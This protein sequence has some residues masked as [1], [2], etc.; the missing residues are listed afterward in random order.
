MGQTHPADEIE[1][2]LGRYWRKLRK[3]LLQTVVNLWP[4]AIAVYAG[5][6]ILAYLCLKLYDEPV[7][8]WLGKK[9]LKKKPAL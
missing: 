7:R 9:F 1:N 3:V 4:M 5:S 8:R 2:R 6:I